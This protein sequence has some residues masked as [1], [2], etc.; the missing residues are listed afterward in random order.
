M[1]EFKFPDE[2]HFL[3][4]LT[5]NI[6]CFLTML[7]AVCLLMAIYNNI[8][9][10]VL[11]FV[12][13][14]F[15]LVKIFESKIAQFVNE[16]CERTLLWNTILFSLLLQLALGGNTHCQSHIRN[17]YKSLYCDNCV[18]DSIIWQCL[19]FFDRTISISKCKTSLGL[20]K[21]FWRNPAV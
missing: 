1:E 8:S 13:V 18:H 16:V 6:L 9:L 3:H 12:V 19:G 14:C 7:L 2:E 15:A 11:L 21:T 20:A 4:N 10:F 17:P 5:G